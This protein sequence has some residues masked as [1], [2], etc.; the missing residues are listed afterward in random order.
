MSNQGLLE[1]F[2]GHTF[3]SGLGQRHLMTL[4]SGAEPFTAEAGAFLAREGETANAFYLI[5]DGHV[6][7]GT[8]TAGR[9]NIRIQTVGPGEVFGWSWLVPPHRW[10]FDCVAVD[11]VR[12]LRFN[13]EWLR[14]ACDQDHDLGYHLV[15]HLAAVFASRL[16]ATRLQLLDIH[17]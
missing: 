14:N 5:Q 4:A 3:L 1:T 8:H 10:Q 15:R 6:A 2:A 7:L 11:A 16:A 17:K 12:G 9:G 13:A